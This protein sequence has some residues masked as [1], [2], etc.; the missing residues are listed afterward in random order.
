M[1]RHLGTINYFRNFMNFYLNKK[2]IPIGR[3]LAIGEE[4]TNNKTFRYKNK[5]DVN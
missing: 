3:L 5:F 4:G 1:V 2:K